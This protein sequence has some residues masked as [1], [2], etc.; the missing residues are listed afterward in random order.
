LTLHQFVLGL[1]KQQETNMSDTKWM[2]ITI[3]RYEGDITHVATDDLDAIL[4]PEGPVKHLCHDDVDM[5]TNVLAD[6]SRVGARFAE[7]AGGTIVL[8]DVE[9]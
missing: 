9:Q 8:A 7:Y 4:H 3:D 1:V 5:T 6:L 2:L